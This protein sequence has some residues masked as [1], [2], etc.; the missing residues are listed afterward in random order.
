MR[1]LTLTYAGFFVVLAF[2]PAP[3]PTLDLW[4]RAALLA[5]LGIIALGYLIGGSN[6]I[7]PR[8]LLITWVFS[9]IISL[10][11]AVWYSNAG[12]IDDRT[13][14]LVGRPFGDIAPGYWG[15][16]FIL[17]TWSVI[18]FRKALFTADISYNLYNI[19]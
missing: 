17:S 3:I 16:Y 8:F 5:N 11:T 19:H 13:N 18:G 2:W 7:S 6:K 10:A 4:M 14:K 9:L 15:N 1:V 12:Y